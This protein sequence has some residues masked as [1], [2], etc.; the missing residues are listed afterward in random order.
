MEHGNGGV[1]FDLDRDYT[2][3]IGMSMYP[4]TLDWFLI[5]SQD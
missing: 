4:K 5:H 3:T 1:T 2:I